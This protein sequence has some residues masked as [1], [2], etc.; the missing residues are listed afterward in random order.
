[1]GKEKHI[2]YAPCR[3]IVHGRIAFCHSTETQPR[4]ARIRVIDEPTNATFS[5][6]YIVYSL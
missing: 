3:Q 4:L 5:G 1:M 2:Q 6:M